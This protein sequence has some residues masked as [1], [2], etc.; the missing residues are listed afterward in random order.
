M[1]WMLPRGGRLGLMH[2]SGQKVPSRLT[3]AVANDLMFLAF[4][5]R[6]GLSR[7]RDTVCHLERTLSRRV[8]GESH[9]SR[10][11]HRI[12]D[13][14]SHP[15]D[16]HRSE[17][18]ELSK[19]NR[20]SLGQRQPRTIALAL[21]HISRDDLTLRDILAQV[22][23][24]DRLCGCRGRAQRTGLPVAA[25][26]PNDRRASRRRRSRTS[27]RVEHACSS[28]GRRQRREAARRASAAR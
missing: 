27:S 6:R 22:G 10:R 14:E 23:D 18:I 8:Q 15:A 2:R 19:S 4:H 28:A 3:L 21:E 26:S 5:D 13:P 9:R 20:R 12:G 11:V 24:A 25:R 1:H 16:G 17:S 7:R